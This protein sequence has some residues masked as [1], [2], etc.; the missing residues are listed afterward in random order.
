MMSSKIKTLIKA[1]VSLGLVGYLIYL[2]DPTKILDVLSRIWN[3]GG[4]PYLFSALVLYIGSVYMLAIR[5]Q[6]LVKGYGHSVSTLVLLK[7]YFIGLFF[8]NFLPTSI[9]GDV[10]RIYHLIQVTGERT[11]G[12]SSVLTERLLGITATLIF[13][14][15]AIF[16]ISDVFQNYLI[17]YIAFG[18]LLVI[19]IFFVL[20]FN[21][22]FMNL[23]LKYVTK[24]K[25]F[26]LG[27]RIIKFLDALRFYQGSK[28]IY[29]K[30]L[31]MSMIA[32]AL[33]ILMTFFLARAVS[34]EIP[35][36]YLF[37]VVPITFLLSM[38]PSINGIGFREGGFVVLLGKVGISQAAA[39]SISFLSVLAPMLISMIGGVLF[40][41]QRK[42]PRKEAIELVEKGM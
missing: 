27:E 15:V 26:R 16:A 34:V 12:F 19:V 25:F 5:W 17:L 9:G 20:V 39:L 22:R 4:L 13:A 33:I 31:L 40:M 11:H 24:I 42:I 41:T 7:F 36:G 32:Q 35:V 14:I 21:D 37:F 23:C 8:N 38:M 2:A 3:Q 10:F 1:L 6:I 30:I 18:M 28:I 29:V